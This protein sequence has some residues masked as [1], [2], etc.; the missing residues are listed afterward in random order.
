[1][2]SKINTLTTAD[3]AP[4][5]VANAIDRVRS[6]VVEPAMLNSANVV[7]ICPAPRTSRP[8]RPLS[9]TKNSTT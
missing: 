8:M 7:S 2:A 1:M 6:Q 9:G 4:P 5:T 3:Q